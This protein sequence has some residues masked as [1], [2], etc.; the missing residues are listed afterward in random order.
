MS[1]PMMFND[2]PVRT[3]AMLDLFRTVQRRLLLLTAA[4]TVLGALVGLLVGGT[5]GVWGALLA[6]A[7]G[8]VFTITT[9]AT[10]RWLAGR[11]PE[12]L[13]IVLIGGWVVKM[14]LVVVVMLWLSQQT[15]YHRGVFFGTLVAVVLGAVAIEIASVAT[16]RIPNV[17]PSG[18][19]VSSVTPAATPISEPAPSGADP[20]DLADDEP[21]T[22]EK[23]T[24]GAADERP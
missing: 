4:V 1:G 15:F 7:L 13:Q 23:G 8:L 3:E 10:L 11:G 9:V 17:E 16:A 6:A 21:R 14:A 5:A 2:P 19:D 20:R 24:P 12:L 18:A 22:P